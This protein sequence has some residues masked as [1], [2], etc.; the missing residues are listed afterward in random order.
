MHDQKIEI[1]GITGIFGP[2]YI[3]KAGE[4]GSPPTLAIH[5]ICKNIVL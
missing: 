4:L 3:A 1:H 2:I 5:R